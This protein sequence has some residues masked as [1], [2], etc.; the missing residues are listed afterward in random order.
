MKLNKNFEFGS[1]DIDTIE[2][3]LRN[4]ITE[5]SQRLLEGG[6]NT[7]TLQK[8][9]KEASAILARIH[10]QKKWFHPKGEIYV[11]G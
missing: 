11:S 1:G 10:H 9:I 2:G 6:P 5:T 8:E 3:A 4:K 7:E